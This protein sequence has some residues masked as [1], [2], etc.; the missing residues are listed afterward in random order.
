MFDCKESVWPGLDPPNNARKN[1]PTPCQKWGLP[2]LASLCSSREQEL[3]VPCK[4]LNLLLNLYFVKIV[5]PGTF[6]SSFKILFSARFAPRIA[7]TSS[8]S[9]LLFVSVSSSPEPL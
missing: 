6:P 2:H 5:L 7:F 4:R 1:G 9:C 8:F 3:L